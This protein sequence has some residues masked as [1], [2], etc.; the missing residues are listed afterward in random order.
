MRKLFRTTALALVF[1]AGAAAAQTLPSNKVAQS[2]NQQQSTPQGGEQQNQGT[3]DPRTMRDETIAPSEDKI[4]GPPES[5]AG[6]VTSDNLKGSPKDD[7][8]GTHRDMA[9][10]PGATPQTMP[11]KYSQE[12]A[13]RAEYSIMGYP[14]QLSDEQR[15]AIWQ[16]VGEQ[17]QTTVGANET[18]HAEPGTFLPP[19]VQGQALPDSLNDN[20]ALRGHKYVRTGDKVL[21]I[22][23][24]NG[25]VR[26]VIEK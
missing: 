26:A 5:E 18:I 2:P 22:R 25:I 13:D 15:Q 9:E 20:A 14:I 10:I 4:V 21:I 17:P 23:P 3:N 12:N 16:A 1:A 19:L 24:A 11:A 6:Q 7:A 8:T